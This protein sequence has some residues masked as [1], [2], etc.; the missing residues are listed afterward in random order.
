MMR[1]FLK[2]M[3]MENCVNERISI[4]RSYQI[5]IFVWSHSQPAC[6]PHCLAAFK[7]GSSNI[8]KIY[9]SMCWEGSLLSDADGQWAESGM[10]F[11]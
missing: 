5:F 7:L 10:S 6:I 1:N 2:R 11:P 8:W 4:P 9:G 3:R